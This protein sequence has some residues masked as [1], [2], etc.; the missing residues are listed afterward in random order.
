MGCSFK[1][2]FCP[3]QHALSYVSFSEWEKE[4]RGIDHILSVFTLINLGK[5]IHDSPYFFELRR[6]KHAP[7]PVRHYW[8]SGRVVFIG[9]NVCKGLGSISRYKAVIKGIH[10]WTDASKPVCYNPEIGFLVLSGF[11]QCIK[12]SYEFLIANVEKY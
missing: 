10:P 9:K 3:V 1:L 11:I 12:L 2:T 8:I 5:E 7:Y 6:V 4:S